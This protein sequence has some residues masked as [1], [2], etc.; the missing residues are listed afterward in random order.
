MPLGIQ[1][2]IAFVIGGGLGLL[3]GWLLGARKPTAA[4]VDSRLENELRQ[5]LG[6]REAELKQT[7][8]LEEG[9]LKAVGAEQVEQQTLSWLEGDR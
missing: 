4:P 3:I 2:A 8:T 9:F 6:Q 7:G 5:Q 1:L